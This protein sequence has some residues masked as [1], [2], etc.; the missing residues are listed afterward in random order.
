[1]DAEIARLLN[2]SQ[3]NDSDDEKNDRNDDENPEQ[4]VRTASRAHR[5]ALLLRVRTQLAT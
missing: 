4:S 2:R 1:M 3:G 5:T